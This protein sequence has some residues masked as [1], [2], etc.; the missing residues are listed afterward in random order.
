[1][2]GRMR[3]TG[4]KRTPTSHY[5]SLKCKPDDNK[6][7]V[8]CEDVFTQLVVFSK[9]A[10]LGKKEENPT[11]KPL[12]IPNCLKVL[13]SD[14]NSC[15]LTVV[16]QETQFDEVDF[17]RDG[18]FKAGAPTTKR[19]AAAET[20]VSVSSGS[21]SSG[22]SGSKKAKYTYDT[23]S[24]NTD[25]DESSN[26]D[27]QGSAVK[28]IVSLKTIRSPKISS[29]SSTKSKPNPKPKPKAKLKSPKK[30]TEV[31]AISGS[32]HGH[33]NNAVTSFVVFH[34]SQRTTPPAVM[35][36]MTMMMMIYLSTL[37]HHPL[38]STYSG[39]LALIV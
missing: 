28:R 7:P 8:Q 1:M 34:L 13:R 12:P 35:T 11:A 2:Q 18:N 23:H 6:N 27:L 25:E 24:D 31:V 26:E 9:A 33:L 20:P 3:L 21:R 16:L 4:Q 5:I 38:A 22:R 17:Q 30:K 36:T 10:W 14:K 37:G 32:S 19:K 29:S 39:F 15:M